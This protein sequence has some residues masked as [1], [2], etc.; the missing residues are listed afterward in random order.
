MND[1]HTRFRTL[2]N[3]SAPNLWYDIEERALA[4]QPTQ[5]R[6]PWVLITVT[7]LLALVIGGAALVGSGIIELPLPDGASP[8]PSSAASSAAPSST[9]EQVREPAWTA[10]G[11]MV[12]VPHG[13]TATLLPDGKV[14]VAGG[15]SSGSARG[16]VAEL[17]SAA[18]YDP[19]SGSWTATGNMIEARSGHT[20]TLLPDGTVLVVGGCC[21]VGGGPLASAELYDPSTG[22]WTATAGM[23]E[24][25]WFHTAT[26]LPDGTVLVAG[27]SI[28]GGGTVASVERYDPDSGSWTATAGMTEARAA[29]TA[30]LLPDGMVLVAGGFSDSLNRASAERY[31]PGSGS[32]TATASMI[33]ARYGHTATLLPD[34]KVLVAGGYSS[35]SARGTVASAE[36]YD[37]GSGSWTPTG[38]MIEA[39]GSHTAT[40]LPDGKVLVAGGHSSSNGGPLASAALYDPGTGSWT[41]TASM[42][43]ARADHTATLLPDGRVLVAGGFIFGGDGGPVLLASAELYDLGSGD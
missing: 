23:I 6:R 1:L 9:P 36:L 31:D 22:S 39:R 3:L 7:L 10:T 35:S 32:W 24:A 26:L 27:G 11:S 30:T 21:D 17:A 34:G 4:M 12:D 18:L 5:R 19:G 25:R 41:A 20:A 40:S 13:H 8:A 42:I 38:S 37:P 2:D 14:L 15:Y 33:E 29:H 28:T 16:T 43:E